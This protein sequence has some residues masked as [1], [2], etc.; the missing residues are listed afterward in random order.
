MPVDTTDLNYKLNLNARVM[1]F[2]PSDAIAYQR[3]YLLA[4][5]GKREEALLRLRE[6]M[7]AYPDERVVEMRR[8]TH[9]AR[10]HP[11]PFL[12]LL[13]FLRQ[14]ARSSPSR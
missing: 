9:L 10:S 8:L 13:E 6:A 7:T 12:P 4:L 1:A 5:S 11:L 2:M 14:D 3:A